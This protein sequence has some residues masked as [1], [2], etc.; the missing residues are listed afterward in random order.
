MPR[1]LAVDLGG[2]SVRAAVVDSDGGNMVSAARRTVD[3]VI[4][5]PPVGRSYD[6]AAVWD[7]TC[8]AI[9][10][11]LYRAGNTEP[12]VAVAATAQRIGCVALGDGDAVLYA[13]PNMDSRGMATAW[14][15]TEA[16]GDDLYPRAGRAL[17]LM[18]APARLVWFRQERPEVF[19]RIRRVMGLGDWLTLRLCG[20]AATEPST[21]ADLLA[22]DVRT[23][24][25]WTELWSRC[26]L[27][28]SWL[29]PLRCAG[30][31]LGGITADAAGR[32]GLPEGTP[33]AVAAP[34]STAA[35]L[36]AG[37]ARPGTTLV[38]AGSTMP[39]LAATETVVADPE[40]RVWFGPHAVR[41]RGVVESNGGTA[42]YGWA[43]TVE[44]LVGAL[45]GLEG[46]A[47]YGQAERLASSAP[48]GAREALLHGGGAG[49][50]NATRP[51]TFLSHTS[52]LL[53][54]SGVLQPDLGAAEVVRASLESVAHGARANVEQAEEVSGGAGQRLAVAGGMA[55]SRLFLRILAAL[56][57]RP[58]HTPPADATMR[59]AAACAA[60]AAEVFADL[61]AAADAM[62]SVS[63]AAIPD[64]ELVPEY[65]AAHRRWRASYARLESL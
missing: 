32:T 26:G 43:W 35:M 60:V 12:V 7:L 40:G 8:A 36:G 14:A 53:W 27:D 57:D 4:D 19:A 28:P 56:M 52:A 16:G 22:L 55:R 59:G 2:T 42:G 46:D 48:A 21:A 39:V 37:A 1:L 30:E 13:G 63:V 50:L 17:A 54:P 65:A 23:G 61:D 29:P 25:Y 6:A 64:A 24:E 58:V 51:A 10:E 49:V 44:R 31:K 11:A 45:S 47:A 3:T 62:G 18:Y 15:V 34:D 38:L 20:E 5:A 41:G 9:R 33:V